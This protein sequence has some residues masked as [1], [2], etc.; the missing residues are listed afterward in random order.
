MKN[1]SSA[2]EPMATLSYSWSSGNGSP[3]G[4]LERSLEAYASVAVAPFSPSPEVYRSER[5]KSLRP[6]EVRTLAVLWR[7][8]VLI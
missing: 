6:D 1:M 8:N 3:H 2:S 4:P 5:G 7:A